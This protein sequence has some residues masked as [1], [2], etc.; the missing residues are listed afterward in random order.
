MDGRAS[1]RLDVTGDIQHRA[2]ELPRLS[3][4]GTRSSAAIIEEGGVETNRLPPI[5][6][7]QSAG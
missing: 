1:F 4:R 3:A 2:I 6:K 5:K 7:A